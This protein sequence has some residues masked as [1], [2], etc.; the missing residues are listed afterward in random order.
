MPYLQAKEEEV[1]PVFAFLDTL[2]A[3]LCA[4]EQELALLLEE[5]QQHAADAQKLR[6]NIATLS[7]DEANDVICSDGS[8]TK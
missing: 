2:A 6:S 5:M 7:Q 8:N 3:Q 1:E 4:S